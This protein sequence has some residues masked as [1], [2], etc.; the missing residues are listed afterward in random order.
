MPLSRRAALTM[1]VQEPLGV[2]ILPRKLEEFDLAAHAR[3]LLEIPRVVAVE[4]SR[5]QRRS[6][7]G[8]DI[9]ALRQAR[10]LRFPGQPKVVVLYTPRD[11]HLARALSARHAA[12]VWYFRGTAIEPP[13]TEAEGAE[14][15]LL[16]QM[17]DEVAV[18]TLVAG[19]TESVRSDN[20]PLRRRLVELEVISAR[21][22]VPGARFK[23]E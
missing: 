17:A 22:F 21:P 16:D 1:S 9:K 7:L 11:Y 19:A 12:E 10:R 23:T 2:L 4:P 8:D 18:Q 6:M 5:F 15:A 13:S 14:L 3:D 20:E